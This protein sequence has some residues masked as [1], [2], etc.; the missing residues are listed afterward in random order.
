MKSL[1]ASDRNSL[2]R[3]AASL[4]K[5]DKQR[6]VILAGLNKISQSEFEKSGGKVDTNKIKR[7]MRRYVE[8][9]FSEYWP[10]SSGD[11]FKSFSDDVAEK[12]EDDL[13]SDVKSGKISP[14]EA[15]ASWKAGLDRI[16][17]EAEGAYER[18]LE[19]A[20]IDDDED[21]A[22]EAEEAWGSMDDWKSKKTR[23]TF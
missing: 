7:E 2:I 17:I 14:E 10:G 15:N 20:E 8:D 23:I 5:G 3:L 13:K 12:L 21:H 19:H 9:E 1:T 6:R 22:S 11:E 18:E 4:P 16:M